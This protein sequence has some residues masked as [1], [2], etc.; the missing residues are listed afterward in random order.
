MQENLFK[1]IMLKMKVMRYNNGEEIDWPKNDFYV[2][3]LFSGM[4]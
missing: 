2:I 1:E 4:M 3:K